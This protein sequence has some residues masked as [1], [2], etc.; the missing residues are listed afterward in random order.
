LIKRLESSV[1]W[2]LRP[3]RRASPAR[4]A[5]Q[6]DCIP[7]LPFVANKDAFPCNPAHAAGRAKII[8]P[9]KTSSGLLRELLS[10]NIRLSFALRSAAAQLSKAVALNWIPA[11]WNLSI[12]AGSRSENSGLHPRYPQGHLRGQ[13]TLDRRC[14]RKVV[15][16]AAYSKW[17]FCTIIGLYGGNFRPATARGIPARSA[18]GVFSCVNPAAVIKASMSLLWPCPAST[19]R[20]APGARRQ[21]ACGISAR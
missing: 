11:F 1:S 8:Q 15:A 18:F 21:A 12:G 17:F 6:F 19:T 4:S 16:P 10:A 3:M 20:T 9:A 13:Q 7:I 2:S 5:V 14:N